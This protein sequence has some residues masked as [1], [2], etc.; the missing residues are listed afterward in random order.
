L[1]ETKK[2]PLPQG[3]YQKYDIPLSTKAYVFHLDKVIEERCDEFDYY[4][5]DNKYTIV[6]RDLI[7]IA[8]SIFNYRVTA[9]R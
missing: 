2:I 8:T 4:L 1:R 3:E 6:A 9:Y 7:P 5:E